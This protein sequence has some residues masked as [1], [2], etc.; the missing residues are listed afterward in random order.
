MS[1]TL[2]ISGGELETEFVLTFFKGNTFDYIIGADRGARFLMEQ[3]IKP[4][5]VVGDFDSS[6]TG[7]LE[8]FREQPDVQIQIFQPEKDLTDTYIAVEKALELCSS[9]IWILGANGTR[10]DHLLANIRTLTLPA[11]RGVKCY[12]LDAFNRMH[13]AARSLTILREDQYGQYVS[14]FAIG[15][16]VEGLTLKGFKYPL[17]NYKMTGEDPIGVSNEIVEKK[18]QIFFDKGLLLVAETRDKSG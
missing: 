7:V 11:R 16:P 14:L 4:T 13:I 5:H 9:E 2:I 10:A 3:G 12:L 8:Y 6:G 18:A 15:G 17:N 1:K